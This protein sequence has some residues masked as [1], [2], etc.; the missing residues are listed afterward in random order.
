MPEISILLPSIRPELARRRIEEFATVAAAVDYEIVLVSP[1]TVENPRVVHVPELER[2]GVMHA[3]NVAYRA[4]SGHHI[5]L[6][7][8]DARP[9]AG[10]LE[11]ILR[12]VGRHPAP[13]L[14][15]F[16]LRDASGRE[17]EQWSVYGRLY[18]GWLCAAKETIDAAGGLFDPAFR[19][20]WA[21]P[22]LSLRMYEIG[23]QVVVCPDAWI[24]VEQVD[25][26]VKQTNL[27]ASFSRDTE[28]FF[29]KW[30]AR[31][32]GRRRVWWR[33][34]TPIPHTLEGRIRGWLRQIPYLK[35]SRDAIRTALRRLIY[36][37][38]S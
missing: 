12:Y 14:A 15:G 37:K 28:T 25:D 4:A 5:V 2:R 34:N 30:H 10:A 26:K 33:I 31:M 22:D 21:D 36:M 19:N 9:M 11:N 17:S 3:M 32:G 8:D 6:W 35:E 7:S 13:M 16:R 23:G 38:H 1:F 29:R 20:Y 18:V 27:S 24:E